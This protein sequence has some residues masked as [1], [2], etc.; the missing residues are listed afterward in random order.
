M[1]ATLKEWSEPS[2]EDKFTKGLN[3]L[4]IDYCP[5]VEFVTTGSCGIAITDFRDAMEKLFRVPFWKAKLRF[6][7]GWL[8]L[9]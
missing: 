6:E 2:Y 5:T 1:R 7:G 3:K 8:T 4:L 9:H